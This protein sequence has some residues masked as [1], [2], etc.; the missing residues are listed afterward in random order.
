MTSILG[1]C[2]NCTH[3]PKIDEGPWALIKN[4]EARE[5]YMMV[6]AAA[7][8]LSYQKLYYNIKLLNE[9]YPNED[10]ITITH[11][12]IYGDYG[13]TLDEEKEKKHK[14]KAVE[15]LK[16]YIKK[17][18]ASLISQE[19]ILAYNQFYYHSQQYQKQ[20]EYGNLIMERGGHGGEVLVGVGGSML[21][22]EL[23]KKNELFKARVMALKARQAWES[24]YDLSIPQMQKAAYQNTFY[25]TSLALT[26]E[27]TQAQNVFDTV[28]K[29][30]KRYSEMERWYQQFNPSN[31][32]NCQPTRQLSGH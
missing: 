23:D 27:C 14:A 5:K 7:G 10:I 6:Q 24:L 11:A 29:T 1:L 3:S 20:L 2:A 8:S 28:V 16:P 12:G 19:R 13:Q 18:Y 15:M 21:A 31:L 17:S 4:D 32:N 22:L 9:L 30:S 25:L 26:G